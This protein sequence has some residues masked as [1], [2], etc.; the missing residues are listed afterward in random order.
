MAG[1]AASGEVADPT[2]TQLTHIEV[3]VDGLGEFRTV[4]D[5]EMQGNVSP[6]STE[7]GTRFRPGAAFGRD[8]DGGGV[9][10]ARRRYYHNLRD[11]TT[12]LAVYTETARLLARAINRLRQQYEEADLASS[13]AMAAAML[14][15]LRQ[16]MSAPGNVSL[17]QQGDLAFQ[18]QPAYHP[19]PNWTPVN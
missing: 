9:L 8:S 19:P 10:G 5:L 13:E 18:P 6:M 17:T 16:V 4:L 11:S 14:S 2:G 3:E 15:E 12:L 1:G 7:V